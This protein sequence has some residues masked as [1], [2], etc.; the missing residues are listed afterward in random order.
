[1][2]DLSIVKI[3][4]PNIIVE[5]SNKETLLPL[6][7]E[8]LIEIFKKVHTAAD[9]RSLMLVN[10]SFFRLITAESSLRKNF[11]SS[12]IALY[13]P[14]LIHFHQPSS[15]FGNILALQASLDAEIALS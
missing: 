8:I 4:N 7:A 1:M 12:A 6:P 9:L 5:Q 11:V 3:N 13:I 2:S 10:Q 15:R 14:K